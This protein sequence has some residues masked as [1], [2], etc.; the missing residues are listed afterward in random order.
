[1]TIIA[2]LH[3]ARISTKTSG[4]LQSS[5]TAE[6]QPAIEDVFEQFA[7]LL[8]RSYLAITIGGRLE[9]DMYHAAVA[10]T[11]HLV[12]PA[13]M[14]SIERIC[15]AEYC[16]ELDYSFFVG[17]IQSSESLVTIL[18]LRAAMIPGHFSD[19]VALCFREAG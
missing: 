9:F 18:R 4:A 6:R 13:V 19:H 7:F 12:D 15:D 14:A 2:S 17:L 8:G 5:T 3:D 1:M 10:N 16:G 11:A